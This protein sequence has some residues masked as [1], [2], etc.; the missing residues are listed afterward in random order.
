MPPCCRLALLGLVASSAVVSAPQPGQALL[1]YSAAG[2]GISG[3]LGGTAFVDASWSMTATA[4]ETLA[5]FSSFT[6]PG[7]GTFDLWW[8]PVSPR[9]T[10]Q[11]MASLL[12]ADLLPQNPYRWLALSGTFPVGP[13]PKIGF[14]YTTPFFN[15]ET[16]AG[17]FG[18]PGSFVNLQSPISFAGSSVFEAHSFPSTAGA[19]VISSSVEVPGVFRIDP[20][21]GPLPAL[22][23]A[24]AFS[25]S[26]RLRARVARQ[27]NRPA[28]CG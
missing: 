26:R 15:P 2:S 28:V 17:V 21:P 10:I 4:D 7:L 25:W 20:V 3:T 27:G 5:T 18:V 22:A 24:G 11:T 8:L 9:V 19:L 13:T 14:V 16:A 23:L 12:E 6:A 1:V